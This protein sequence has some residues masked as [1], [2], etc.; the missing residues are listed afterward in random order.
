MGEPVNILDLARDMIRLYN[1]T[2]GQDI[3]IVFS[4]VRPGEKL[5]E[6]LSTDD[7][8]IAKTRHPK[9]FIGKIAPYR[10]KQITH[11]LERMAYFAYA[12]EER[13]LLKLLSDLLPESDLSRP[14]ETGQGVEGRIAAS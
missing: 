10:P 3:E 9:I 13:S 7:E 4:G 1:L 2:P 14:D 11:A 8:Q 12:G 6:Q 5:F